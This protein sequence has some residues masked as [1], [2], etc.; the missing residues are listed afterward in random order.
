M[1]HG[2]LERRSSQLP[3]KQK[4]LKGQKGYGGGKIVGQTFKEKGAR[5]KR[6]NGLYDRN[7]GRVKNECKTG[8]G[9]PL[10]NEQGPGADLRRRPTLIH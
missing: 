6:G 7:Q 5:P 2:M 1:Q 10:S 9:R 8:R 4:K 3:S